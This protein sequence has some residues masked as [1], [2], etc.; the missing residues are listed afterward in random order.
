MV[1]LYIYPCLFFFF[2]IFLGVRNLLKKI[3]NPL[4]P[5]RNFTPHHP[6]YGGITM[7]VNG[8]FSQSLDCQGFDG[9]FEVGI[10]YRCG[11][12]LLPLWTNQAFLPLGTDPPTGLIM[13]YVHAPPL[14]S[15]LKSVMI[16]LSFSSVNAFISKRLALSLRRLFIVALSISVVS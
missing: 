15:L 7:L 3:S 8:K 11:Q 4:S 9:I 2:F 6:L 1:S 10:S 14:F 16:L 5:Y 13:V 12:I